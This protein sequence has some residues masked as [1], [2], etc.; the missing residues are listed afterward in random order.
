MLSTI[1]DSY[2]KQA[3]IHLR[4]SMQPYH[5]ISRS[6]LMIRYQMTDQHVGKWKDSIWQKVWNS[7]NVEIAK[8]YG[9]KLQAAP[10]YLRIIQQ[11]ERM[12]HSMHWKISCLLIHHLAAEWKQGVIFLT[13]PV[14]NQTAS[15]GYLVS[16]PQAI[17]H[18]EEEG[19]RHFGDRQPLWPPH[20]MEPG[21]PHPEGQTPQESAVWVE[22]ET[23]AL[24]LR[25]LVSPWRSSLH[26]TKP[27]QSMRCYHHNITA[28]ELEED[29]HSNLT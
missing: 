12:L 11:N 21:R 26:L 7:C 13:F 15:R 18:T 25:T 6:P 17:L 23:T 27:R 4:L 8:L 9:R 22:H 29:K 28:R 2:S 16:S 10:P 5:L 24:H 14:R 3:D 19:R 1:P 20:R